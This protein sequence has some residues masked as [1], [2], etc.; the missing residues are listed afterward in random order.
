MSQ[1][2]I[3]RL[4]V[5]ALVILVVGACCYW[6]GVW[7]YVPPLAQ[8]WA[9]HLDR[10][11]GKAELLGPAQWYGGGGELSPD[12]RKMVIRRK[13]RGQKEFLMWN[14][15]TGEQH[16]L[17]IQHAS[18]LLWLNADQFVVFDTGPD[19]YYLV[20]ARDVTIVS[21][22]IFPEEQYKQPGGLERVQSLW[23]EAD[24]VYVVDTLGMAGYTIITL[25]HGQPYVYR[26]FG[27]PDNEV[28]ALID[29][30]PHVDVPLLGWGRPTLTNERVYSPDGRFYTARVPAGWVESVVIYTRDG[31]LVARAYKGG[32]Q[33]SILGW[34]HDS[35]GVYFEMGISGSSAACLVPY[36]PLFKLS[37]FTEA[38]ARWAMVWRVGK[39]TGVLAALGIGWWLWKRRRAVRQ[40]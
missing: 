8:M 7:W 35:S 25:E 19:E 30:I 40:M 13:R 27:I 29:D 3:R 2:W 24:Q 21:A 31:K 26:A 22:T 10:V 15:V 14:L 11:K 16:L 17:D 28:E 32:W 37:P 33:P 34:A 20:D 18:W 23:R 9:N 6:S 38:E 5:V 4:P 39:W 1:K 12:G 36:K